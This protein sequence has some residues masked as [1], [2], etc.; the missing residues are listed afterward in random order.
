MEESGKKN[1]NSTESRGQ[2]APFSPLDICPD[3]SLEGGD[4]LTDF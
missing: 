4:D 3:L 1:R 2:Y